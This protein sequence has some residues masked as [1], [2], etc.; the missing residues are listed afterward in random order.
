MAYASPR[1][2][3]RST[4]LWDLPP[5]Y[6]SG[7]PGPHRRGRPGPAGPR[8]RRRRAGRRRL[9][10]PGERHGVRRRTPG[11]ARPRQ[12]DQG[13]T[14]PRRRASRSPISQRRFLGVGRRPRTTLGRAVQIGTAPT[15]V[16]RD[17][18]PYPRP[19]D[20][21]TFYK[22]TEPLRLVRG[23][24]LNARHG[25]RRSGQQ[26]GRDLRIGVQQEGADPRRP[27]P[28]P[29]SAPPPDRAPT[30]PAGIPGSARAPTGSVRR[31]STRCAATGPGRGGSRPWRRRRRRRRHRGPAPA[32]PAPPR[33]RHD[34]GYRR[35]T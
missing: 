7:R 9:P 10:R 20:R 8:R 6:R 19:M 17:G 2:A 15:T 14:G 35:T 28:A 12:A 11:A 25:R 30:A 4:D 18:V 27:R 31:P 13:R 16:V 21:W 33:H 29:R 22:H 23:L 3:H 5:W 34:A 24:V 32:R 1:R 26:V